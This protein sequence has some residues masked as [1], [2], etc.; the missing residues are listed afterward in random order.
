MERVR[1]TVVRDSSKNERRV[2]VEELIGISESVWR[3]D[4]VRS[5][6]RCPILLLD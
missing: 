5:E 6:R 2:V 3:Y 1:M 4:F